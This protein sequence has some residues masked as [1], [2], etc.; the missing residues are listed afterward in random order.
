[1]ADKAIMVIKAISPLHFGSGESLG[2]VDRPIV[3]EKASTFPFAPGPS[4]KGRLRAFFSQRLKETAEKEIVNILFGP[5]VKHGADHEGAISF[6]D[7]RLLAFPIRCLGGPFIW[8]T[9][10]LALNR[11]A[12]TLDLYI[13]KGGKDTRAFLTTKSLLESIIIPPS[14]VDKI[15]I[16]S[17]GNQRILLEEFTLP[18][19]PDS[20]WGEL[21]GAL[22]TLLFTGDEGLMQLYFMDRF[23]ILPEEVFAYFLAR[24]TAVFANIAIGDKGT[25]SDGSL[26][27]TEYLPEDTI[28]YSFLSFGDGRGL[29]KMPSLQV[30]SKFTEHCPQRAIQMGGDETTGKGIV[31]LRLL[32]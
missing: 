25:T 23:I 2:L 1:M 3:R 21:A 32:P 15:A 30:C 10:P 4:I 17:A 31:R 14:M 12:E 20:D 7:G 24:A 19:T 29:E 18:V 26:R 6:G 13:D 16:G 8:A 22:S 27:Y 5:D 28:L 9:S 11:F